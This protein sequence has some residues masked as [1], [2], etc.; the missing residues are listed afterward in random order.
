MTVVI[1]HRAHELIEALPDGGTW[2]DLMYG[3]DLRA[4]VEAGLADAKAGRVTE[5]GELRRDCGLRR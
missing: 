1:R 3:L 5:V 2:Q 4:D